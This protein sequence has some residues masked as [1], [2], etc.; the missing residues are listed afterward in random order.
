MKKILQH[1]NLKVTFILPDSFFF[2]IVLFFSKHNI[3][4]ENKT[5]SLYTWYLLVLNM[6]EKIKF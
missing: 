6:N 3:F 4:N 2:Q 5:Y 1:F